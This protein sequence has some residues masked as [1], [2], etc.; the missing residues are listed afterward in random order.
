MLD[1]R[2]PL[3]DILFALKHG[4]EAGRLPDWDD[5]LAA[6]VLG[7]AGRFIDDIIAPLDPVGDVEGCRLE[8][9]RVRM[10]A[11]FRSAYDAFREGG[12]PALSIEEAYGG[13]GLPHILSGALSEMLSGAC[14]S[15]Q[16]VLSLAQ[17][18]MRTLSVHGSEGQKGLYIPKLASGDWLA[19]MCLTEPQAGSDLSLVRTTAV[20]DG[21]SWRITGNKIFISGG[22]QDLTGKVLHLVLARTGDA[23]AG[24]KGLSLF[25][26]P[27]ECDQG[28]RNAVSVIRLEEK[29]GMHASPTCQLAF[30]DAAAEIVGKPGEG[31]MRMFTMMNQQR[32]DVALQGVGLADVAAQRSLAYAATRRQ[33]KI[34][35]RSGAQI[36]TAHDDVR[37]MLLTQKAL[38]LGSRAMTLRTLV[39]L[40]LDHSS[41]L[42]DFLTPVCKAFCT[43]AA[44]QAADQAIQIH[45]GYGYLREYRVEQV[46]RDARIT[47]IYEGTNGIQAATLAGRLLHAD[48]GRAAEAFRRDIADTIAVSGGPESRAALQA[49]LDDWQRATDGVVAAASQSAANY[50]RLTGLLAFGAAWSRLEGGADKA[51]QP[52]HVRSVAEF[53]RC[54]MLPETAHLARLCTSPFDFASVPQDIFL[55]ETM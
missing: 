55:T 2:T 40:E 10:P 27:S 35:G 7:H 36:L 34:A 21:D 46:L 19:T 13:Q 14:I 52:A 39:E 41:P 30:D 23:A 15:F 42:V 24:I 9:G 5:D 43:D 48:G 6:E 1:Y 31:L 25:V 28:I 18:A 26:C 12:W 49:A 54:A 17:A 50:M 47:P 22:D 8:N 44:V 4:A 37:R 11:A 51:P 32:L 53:V 45:G 33:G 16:M 20:P 38:T 29:M 3:D